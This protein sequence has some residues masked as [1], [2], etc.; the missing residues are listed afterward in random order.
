[1]MRAAAAFVAAAIL[2]VSL[3]LA[4]VQKANAQ[5]RP[6]YD[7]GA[8]GLGQ[9]LKRLQT[10]A[11]ALHT[12]AHPDD[13]DSGLLAYLAR[14][15][16]SRTAYLSLNRGDGG[17]NV[18]GQE[19][20]EGLGVIRT[21]EL[22]QARRLDG[23]QQFFTRTMDY[24]FSKTRAEAAKMWGEREVLGDMV[25][26][27]RLFRPLVVIG[28]FSGTPA[29]GHGQHQLAGYL[30]PLAF[31]AAGDPNEFPEHRAEG[32]DPWQPLKLY[33]SQGFAANPGN[34]PTLFLNTGEFDQLIGRSYFE[35]AMEGRSQHKSQE[36][37]MLE[38]RGTQRSGMRLMETKANPVEK[39]SGVF[40]GIDTSITGIMQIARDSYTPA[41]P[42]LQKLEDTAAEALRSYNV[43][44]PQ[45]LIPILAR[46]IR[47]AR[48]AEGSTRNPVSKWLIREKEKEF[49]AALQAAAGV[50]V[51]ALSNREMIEPGTA[52][53]ISVKTFAPEGSTVKVV[54]TELKAPAGWTV[55]SIE[56]PKPAPATGFRPRN[57]TA[58]SA[59]FFKA[60][61]PASAEPTQPYWMEKPRPGAKFDWSEAGKA[62]NMPFDQPLMTAVVTM[63]VDGATFT[64]EREAQFRFADDIRG[65]IRRAVNVVPAVTVGLESDLLIV[66][67]ASGTKHRIVTTA[68]NNSG[69]A[70]SGTAGLDVP[71]GWAVSPRS[72]PFELKNPGDKTAFAFEVT[73]PSGAAVGKYSVTAFAESG[74]K[75][76]AQ[77]MQEIAYPHIQT[78]RI[79]TPSAITAHVLDLKVAPVK[80]GYIMG[81]GDKVPEAIRRLGLDVTMLSEKDLSTGDL[82]Q[83]DTV[84]VGI[85]ASQTRP[86]FVANNGRLLDFA[87]NGGTLIVQ[88]QQHEYV[89]GNLQ[90][91]PA[92]MT[93]VTRGNQRISNQRVTDENA[94]VTVLVPGHP[95]FNFPNKISDADWD[96][97]VQERNLYSFTTYDPQY[98]PLLESH[99]EGE[100]EA[101][102]GMLYAKI[103]KGQYLYTSYS[104]FRQLPAGTPGA[105]RIFANILSLSK[106]EKK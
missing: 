16:Q 61:S 25:R 106:S 10:T 13:E 79:F 8:G 54:K 47:E 60:V 101:T 65:E 100:D 82:S 81:S 69:R 49:A 9:M 66:P 95:I 14:K 97:W 50:V 23:G 21:E 43:Y 17:Q 36:M 6:I 86:D 55:E 34:E 62:K 104:W 33:M 20:F 7:M 39:E 27:I 53:E 76:Y 19:L 5:V 11:S 48:E 4:G 99:D 26:T 88:Y 46:G 75:R 93:G 30:T 12:A 74:D 3:P 45:K 103:G 44:E 37:G 52:A 67:A 22:L 73:I 42:K 70:I 2:T 24:G 1:M 77:K 35:I 56:E 94:K 87:R 84:V 51:D 31:K 38:L 78:H 80:I 92:S 83:F 58:T 64:V 41:L 29:D 105:Y 90:P 98:T 32:L 91:F 85:R 89:Q 18:I 63:E 68:Q 96:N 102:G 57:E 15:E 72:A 59:A 28:R 71:A 40:D